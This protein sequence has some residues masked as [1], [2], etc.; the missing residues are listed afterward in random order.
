LTVELKALQTLGLDRDPE[1]VFL[2]KLDDVLATSSGAN[3]VGDR[4]VGDQ[5]LELLRGP[6]VFCGSRTLLVGG[7]PEKTLAGAMVPVASV[8]CLAVLPVRCL[9]QFGD[10]LDLA[11]ADLRSIVLSGCS[12]RGANLAETDL[13]GADLSL[14]DLKGAC[15]KNADLRGANLNRANLHGADLTQADLRRAEMRGCDLRSATFYRTALRGA[16][17]WSATVWNVDFSTSFTEGAE[18]ERA[19]NRG[20]EER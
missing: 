8:V 15:L 11:G 4:L 19:D 13:R 5:N 16:D 18:I 17:F 10:G 12:L 14:A 6:A 7:L 20:S 9:L 1:T 3:F 2:I